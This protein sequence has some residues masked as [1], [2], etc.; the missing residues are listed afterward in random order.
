MSTEKKLG[1]MWYCKVN[2]PGKSKSTRGTMWRRFPCIID[3]NGCDHK[4]AVRVGY[5]MV[6]GKTDPVEYPEGRF[7]V[8]TWHQGKQT[9][10][11]LMGKDRPIQNGRDAVVMWEAM[12]RRATKEAK[13]AAGELK[14]LKTIANAKVAYVT[15]LEREQKLEAAENAKL[16]LT[17]F[18]TVC[19]SDHVKRITRDNVLDYHAAL[20]KRGLSPRT[21]AN[22]HN[23]LKSFLRWC[24]VDTK[25]M[26]D[27][28]KYDKKA[29]ATI[30]TPEQLHAL[31]N[32][33]NDYLR[34]AIDM[35]LMLGLRD[36]ELSH[37]CWS[38][39]DFHTR[40]FRVTS[41]PDL[42]FRIKDSEERLLPCPVELLDRLRKWKQTTRGSQRLILG[43]KHR[44]VNHHI[45]RMLKT[46]A[47]KAGLNCG[48]C[49]TCLKH[50]PDAPDSWRYMTIRR[51]DPK[52]GQQC[53]QFTLH[54]LRRSYLT[55]MLRAGV[56]ARTVQSLAGHSSLQTTLKYLS[57]ATADQMQATVNSIAWGSAKSK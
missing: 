31:R 38:D 35:A 32:T 44:A 39:I 24:K 6:K 28:P 53:Q 29:P 22:R 11:T 3:H 1:L 20:R 9:Y 34:L 55:I 54:K 17:E 10:Q 41:K 21:I 36:Q 12:M 57:P 42:G 26:P 16:V 50:V 19:S 25:F 23:R 33:A 52:A 15:D 43:T 27:E 37:A 7:Q 14:Q 13:V 47:Q 30:Y 4:R 40:T 45:L 8:R 18:E 51:H 2:T 56:D 46:L 5:V 49:V 48:A